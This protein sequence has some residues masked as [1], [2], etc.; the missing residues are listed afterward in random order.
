MKFELYWRNFKN[1]QLSQ[2]ASLENLKLQISEGEGEV[3]SSH[4]EQLKDDIDKWFN[5][6]FQLNVPNWII[7]PFETDLFE[8]NIDL[9]EIFS[10]IQNDF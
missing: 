3:F 1:N 7:D 8:V 4:L 2:F 6:V 5:D 10:D 9:Q